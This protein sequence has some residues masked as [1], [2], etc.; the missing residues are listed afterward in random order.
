MTR[1]VRPDYGILRKA[2]AALRRRSGRRRWRDAAK[3]FLTGASPE[4][5]P[6]YLGTVEDPEPGKVGICCSGGGV[7]SAA[8]NLG[9]LQLLAEKNV[10][11]RARYIAAVSGGSYIAA[12]ISMVAKTKPGPR[13]ARA[14]DRP[15]SAG[16]DSD[17]SLFTSDKPA[18]HRGSPEEQ[19]LRNR[20]SYLAPGWLDKLFLG[21]RVLLGTVFNLAFVG[22]FLVAATSTAVVLYYRDAYPELVQHGPHGTFVAQVPPY[23]QLIMLGLAGAGLLLVLVTLLFSVC[24]DGLRRALETWA[25]RLLLIAFGLGVLTA[26][27]PLLVEVV[28]NHNA[29]AAGGG[30]HIKL[31]SPFFEAGG[32]SIA[33]LLA[34]ALAQLRARFSDPRKV[35]ADGKRA[36]RLLGKLGHGARVA[37]AYV[38]VGIAG[39]V[40]VLLVVT[41]AM[42]KMFALPDGHAA[43][44]WVPLASVGVFWLFYSLSDLTSWSLHRF[45]KRRLCTAYALKRVKRTIGGKEVAV[46]EERHFDRLVPLSKTG[47]DGWPTLLVCAAANISDT[48]ATPPGRSVTSFVFSETAVGGPLVGAVGTEELEKSVSKRR[49]RDFTLPAAVAMSGAAISPSMGKMT[50]SP[51]TFL[52]ALLN[53]RLG[54]WVPN[55]RR[56][57]SWTKDRPLSM[58]VEK[59]LG[60]KQASKL[61]V[62][63]WAFRLIPFFGDSL[64]RWVRG[65]KR[66]VFI[67]RPRPWYLL[68]ELLG[69][70]RIDAKF[71]YVTDGGHY[72]NLGLVELLR[73]G[74]TEIYCFDAS[75]GRALG[76]LA[77]AIS[78]ARSELNVDIAI[79][80]AEDVV[81]EKDSKPAKSDF[82]SGTITYRDHLDPHGAPRTGT[83][84]YARTVMTE[85]APVDVQV[86]HE[87]D[88]AFPH[89]STADQLYTDQKFEAYRALGE[90]AAK[91]AHE[92]M[93][94]PPPAPKPALGSV[95]TNGNGHRVR[96]G[97][98]GAMHVLGIWH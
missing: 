73:R 19:Y 82:V 68:C 22:L 37:L 59:T 34:A 11:Q 84:V 90:C 60:K 44:T 24:P 3:T 69:R 81:P 88:Q 56:V 55:P 83:L 57:D 38:A 72:E 31:D 66:K 50:R 4:P 79:D 96:D 49:R 16:D 78:L 17:P 8:F 51:L 97:F 75:G 52:M 25:L 89:N 67:P 27:L 58:L 61:R 46:A 23:W 80:D 32:A 45:Y 36:R 53:V 62:P 15:V 71:L 20:S 87:E 42:A 10:F 41:G 29:K 14:P 65:D 77:D 76:Q 85:G 91:R 26:V 40:L 5:I 13:G 64:G 95:S 48:A 35:M 7:R 21:C 2:P 9:A 12:A 92:E 30:L 43:L 18:F 98:S 1:E 94:A 74:C 93:S 39:P 63:D 86:R 33:T 70:N 6:S 47:V 54:V 28:R